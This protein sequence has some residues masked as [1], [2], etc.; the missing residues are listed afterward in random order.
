METEGVKPEYSGIALG[1]VFTVGQLGAVSAPPLGNALE[2]VSA[3]APFYFW[4]ALGLASF[5]ILLLYRERRPALA[6]ERSAH[7]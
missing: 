1:M 6:L 5:V 4:A 7:A 2:A 3:G